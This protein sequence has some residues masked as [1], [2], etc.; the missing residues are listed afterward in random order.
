MELNTIAFTF[1]TQEDKAMS[2]RK[3]DGEHDEE[4]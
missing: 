3:R 4:Y 2:W 1:V